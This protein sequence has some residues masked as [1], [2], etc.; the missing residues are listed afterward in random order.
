MNQRCQEETD[1]VSFLKKK[2]RSNQELTKMLFDELEDTRKVALRYCMLSTLIFSVT[3]IYML[4]V[5]GR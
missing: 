3:I 5:C 4:A 2:L 1:D